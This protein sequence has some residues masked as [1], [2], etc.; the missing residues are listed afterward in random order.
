M[1]AS[2]ARRSAP[3]AFHR[4]SSVPRA[5]AGA[6]G[7][8]EN[9][10]GRAIGEEGILPVLACYPPPVTGS[11]R[12][13]PTFVWVA[14]LSVAYLVTRLVA[15][16]AL[17]IFFDETG[18]IRWAIWI[19]QGQKIEKPWQYGKGLPIFANALLFPWARD[20]ALWASRALTVL[21]GA[22]TLTGAVLLGRALGGARVGWLA[23]LFYVACPYALLYDRL[24]LTDPALG[25]FAV[26]VALLSLRLAQRWRGRDGVALG[27]A[28]AL[29]VFAKALGALLFFAPAAAVLLIAPRRLRR[30]GPLVIAYLIG[31]ALVAHP[32][33]RYF[34]VTATVRVAVSKSDAGLWER[35]AANLPLA[36]SWLWR[37][38]TMGLIALALIALAHAVRHRSRPV[39]FVVVFLALPVLGFAAVG[40][41]WFPR[42][43]VFL[44]G[45]FV[46]L[47]AVGADALAAALARRWPGGA[48]RAGAVAG[49]VLALL[50]SARLDLELLRDPARAAL[51]DLDRFQYVTGWPSGYGVRDTIAFVHAE[52][53]RHP[54]G[55][56]V[57][58]HSRTVRTTA[59]ALDLEFAYGDGVRVEDLNFDHP[60]AM[61][62]LAE[63][64]RERPTLV[65]IEPAQAKSRRPDPAL[66][67]S[68]GG[69][70]AARTYKPDGELCDEIYR[71]CG[72]ARCAP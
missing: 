16:T 54:E 17:P 10:V 6:L 20:H 26:F 8:V 51:V 50:P 15:L 35:L 27:L 40:D 30:P 36:A 48:G 72:G 1:A 31:G 58:T 34:Q 41:I 33:L 45:P 14:G 59:R 55:L 66:F 62:L 19:S 9:G 2:A 64:A 18:H 21:F 3:A 23:G 37:Y 69:V 67:A 47:A 28:L 7:V 32:L 52:R 5:D 29:A 22:G 24:A 12:L 71:L 11:H 53:A 49:L 38:W 57:V 4:R 44:T 68:L 42:Y 63:W 65:V 39:G 56:T 61:P 70:V 25:M 46:A 60:A 43:L 13:S